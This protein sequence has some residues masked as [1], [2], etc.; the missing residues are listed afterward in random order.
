MSGISIY[1]LLAGIVGT[2]AGL[3][4]QAIGRAA[5]SRY[6]G[7]D[8][9]DLSGVVGFRV[10]A[11]FG[12][13]VGLIFAS[14]AAHLMEA[15]KDVLEEARLMATLY[16]LADTPPTPTNAAAVREN[17]R[18]YIEQSAR[19][20]DDPDASHK[21][22]PATNRLLLKICRHMA[23]DDQDT[24]EA[25][26]TKSEFQRSCSK[27]ID[28]RG[29]K[30]IGAKETHVSSPFWIFFAISF[31]FLAILFGVFE[32]RLINII[33]A[34]LFYFAAGV[35]AMLIYAASNPYL[36]PGRISSAPLSRL[37]DQIDAN[38]GP[39]SS[40]VPSESP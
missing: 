5:F 16:V 14:T 28:I 17:V 26:W 39:Q 20:M 15:K 23:L 10:S 19:E 2:V 40:S 9:R 24:P 4:L 34:S 29:K 6:K 18:Q 35:T 27:L 8:T 38:G 1:V 3:I 22:A 25:R 33:F 32:P 37:L 30:R 13:A 36:D 31:S 11:V 7:D 21:S 12:I